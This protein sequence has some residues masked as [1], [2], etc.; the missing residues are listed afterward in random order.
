MVLAQA[1]SS[2]SHNRGFETI[3]AND[4]E[5]KTA[6]IELESQF[7]I[8]G[9]IIEEGEDEDNEDQDYGQ[10]C[11]DEIEQLLDRICADEIIDKIKADVE[12][13]ENFKTSV[14]QKECIWC[15]K[16]SC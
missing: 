9:E 4:D 11:E 15:L 13:F 1:E 8:S 10:H 12:D 14:I 3:Y 16:E 6:E 5:K 2:Y 7:G